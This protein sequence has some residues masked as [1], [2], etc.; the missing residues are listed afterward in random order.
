MSRQPNQTTPPHTHQELASAKVIQGQAGTKDDGSTAPLPAAF[1]RTGSSSSS[2]DGNGDGGNGSGNERM[3]VAS[4]LVPSEAAPK[5]V[6]AT[7]A[8]LEAGQVQLLEPDTCHKQVLTRI[9]VDL[10]VL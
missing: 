10:V 9:V 2:S 1:A 3:S 7:K 5:L 6:E 8:R 4:L